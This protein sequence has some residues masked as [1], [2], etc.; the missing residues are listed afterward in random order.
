MITDGGAAFKGED[1]RGGET[2]PSGAFSSPNIYFL[3]LSYLLLIL[4]LSLVSLGAVE[5]GGDV[6]SDALSDA[7]PIEDEEADKGM[8]VAV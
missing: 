8:L 7:S 5:P 3:N 4:V 2:A 1:D 6:D